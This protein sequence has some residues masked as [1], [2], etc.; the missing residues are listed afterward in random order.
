MTVTGVGLA[1]LYA[2]FPDPA[3]SAWHLVPGVLL[4][5][6]GMG[7]MIAPLYN[8]ILAG[9]DDHEVG[10]ASGFLTAVQQLGSAIG[11][12][13]LGTLFIAGSFAAATIAMAGTLAITFGLVSC[14][15][16]TP[17]RRPAVKSLMW[18]T[19]EVMACTTLR[20]QACSCIRE[21]AHRSAGGIAMS[22]TRT[23]P[24]YAVG[25]LYD[26]EMSPDIISYIEQIEETFQPFHGAWVVHGTEPEVLEGSLAADI[27][28][29]GFPSSD[30]ARAWYRSQAYR[31]LIRL[32]AEHSRSVIV[33]VDGVPD[34]YRA[35]ETAAKLKA[36]H[37][38]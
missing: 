17:D 6:L 18:L 14:C 16:C 3:E 26:L 33:L 4:I 25:L 10:S 13:V 29:I 28:I 11:V 24:C 7:L 32:R 15:P 37:R 23:V 34:G 8:F 21:N 22:S 19:S 27:V 2:L 38:L 20:H 30:Y 35:A 31:D 1:T 12:A 9:V 5:G 36:M